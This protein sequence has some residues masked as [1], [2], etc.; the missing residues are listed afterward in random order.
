MAQALALNSIF[1]KLATQAAQVDD[2]DPRRMETYLRLALKAQAQSRA[3]LEAMVAVGNP[4]VLFAQQANVAFGPQQVNNGAAQATNKPHL[5]ADQTRPN[6]LIEDSTHERTQ[7]D[8]GAARATG[9]E[10]PSLAPM[11]E[12]HGSAKS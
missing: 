10:D 5:P 9:R 6:E 11:G 12:I 7:M 8:A 1:T 2:H 3:T 4:P